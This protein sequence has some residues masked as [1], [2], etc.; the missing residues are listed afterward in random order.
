MASIVVDNG[1]LTYTTLSEFA[2]DA[3]RLSNRLK[4]L[5]NENTEL[6]R[7]TPEGRAESAT[8]IT[9][10]RAQLQEAQRQI[11]VLRGSGASASSARSQI[12]ELE[13]D[14][15][16]ARA[17]NRGLRMQVQTTNRQMQRLREEAA[18]AMTSANVLTAIQQANELFG[19]E[20]Q[21][22]AGTESTV[23]MEELIMSEDPD[24][25]ALVRAQ[26]LERRLLVEQDIT[27]A[28]GALDAAQVARDNAKRDLETYEQDNPESTLARNQLHRDF[29]NADIDTLRDLNKARITLEKTEI[30]LRTINELIDAL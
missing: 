30:L 27:L 24:V 20:T 4:A 16:D 14:L 12:E 9:R 15:L 18:S 2:G 10:L 25:N 7:N 22:E 6:R 23:D 8:T 21:E 28:Q 5:E 19:D 17:E 26:L 1:L 11:E 3:L 13:N 29:W